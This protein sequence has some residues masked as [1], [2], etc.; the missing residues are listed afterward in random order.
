MRTPDRCCGTRDITT[1]AE[2][3]P[4]RDDCE[5]HRLFTL[6]GPGD[7]PAPLWLC[8]TEGFEARMPLARAGEG[9]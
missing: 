3:C 1:T 4:H 5:R 6:R 2:V 8:Q 7:Q 9:A